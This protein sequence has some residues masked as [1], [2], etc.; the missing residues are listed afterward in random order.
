MLRMN[1]DS[2]ANAIVSVG[3][4]WYED[5]LAIKPKDGIIKHMWNFL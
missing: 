3:I 4:E 5:L 1:A 2:E